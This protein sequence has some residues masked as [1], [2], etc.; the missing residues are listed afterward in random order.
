MKSSR[1]VHLRSMNTTDDDLPPVEPGVEDD[2]GADVDDHGITYVNIDDEEAA[3]SRPWLRTSVW[4]LSI[5]ILIVF[6]TLPLLRI[7]VW[8]DDGP[9]DHD[10]AARDARSFVATQFTT[11]ALEARSVSAAQRWVQPELA[12]TVDQIVGRLQATSPALIAGSHAR[13]ARAACREP[14]PNNAE[15]FHAWLA[16][17]GQP[18]IIRVE[19]VIG[20]VDGTA[21]II[22]LQT[23]A[24]I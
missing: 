16:R 4:L 1:P 11:D 15:C 21:T 24:S 13:V 14:A 2:D 12:E 19:L 9:S 8:A 20:I 17:A 18:E 6:V 10:T 22:D 7:F 5:F 3:R 23:V